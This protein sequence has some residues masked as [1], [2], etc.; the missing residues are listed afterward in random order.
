MQSH[1]KQ[2]HNNVDLESRVGILEQRV[3]HLAD[4]QSATEERQTEFDRRLDSFKEWTRD[5]FLV[6]QYR[7]L[8]ALE[9][10]RWLYVGVVCGVLVFIWLVS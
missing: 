4:R 8:N 7:Q 2:Q 10:Q 6:Q 1:S 3:D 9:R 5:Q